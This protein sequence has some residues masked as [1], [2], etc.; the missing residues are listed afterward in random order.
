MPAMRRMKAIQQ[1]WCVTDLHASLNIHKLKLNRS[2]VP[3]IKLWVWLKCGS[4]PHTVTWI[5][6]RLLLWFLHDFTAYFPA[7]YCKK[8]LNEHSTKCHFLGK[9]SS[10]GICD[11]GGGGDKLQVL[12]EFTNIG[13]SDHKITST[14]TFCCGFLFFFF[15]SLAIKIIIHPKM[16][17]IFMHLQT[18]QD[19]D[20]S[21]S[22]S[23]LEKCIIPSLA[24][25][26]MLCG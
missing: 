12:G 7:L 6:H 8:T 23:D 1:H 4:V 25:Q 3:K 11:M 26:W 22:S 21:V 19:V 20:E 10:Y 17:L 16:C 9:M 18:I 15:Y 24:H 5:T 14:F 13:K 2:V